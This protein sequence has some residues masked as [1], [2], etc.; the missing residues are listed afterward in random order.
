[1]MGLHCPKTHVKSLAVVH[2]ILSHDGLI[3]AARDCR[4]RYALQTSHLERI[5]ARLA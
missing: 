1:M 3:F 4:K 5:G 2:A